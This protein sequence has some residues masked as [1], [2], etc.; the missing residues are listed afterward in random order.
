MSNSYTKTAFAFTLKA[1]ETAHL[2]L[3]LRLQDLLDEHNDEEAALAEW[4][5]APQGFRELFPSKTPNDPL[6]GFLAIFSDT[7]HPTFG[8]SFDIP[9]DDGSAEHVIEVHGDEFDPHSV[10]NLLAAIIPP[11]AT[12]TAT[13]AETSDRMRADNFSGGGFR[14]HGGKLDWI[15][16]ADVSDEECFAPRF[17]L[18]TID[19]Y[20]GLLF[21]NNETGFGSLDCATTFAEKD[22]LEGRT[23][24][25]SDNSRWLRVPPARYP[26]A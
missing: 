13:W 20:D 10:A 16:A 8:V 25:P 4:Q 3:A 19:A 24:T 17:V 26:H 18:A 6:S 22:T 15:T 14:I 11:D 12:V 23:T 7:D 1:D 21:W 2:R 5:G 9:E